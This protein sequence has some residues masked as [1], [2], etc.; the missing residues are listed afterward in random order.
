MGCGEDAVSSTTESAGDGPGECE[1][2]ESTMGS[3][4]F[5]GVDIS[6]CPSTAPVVRCLAGSV[7]TTT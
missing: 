3:P 2:P 1:L 5:S 6:S 7:T 4:P